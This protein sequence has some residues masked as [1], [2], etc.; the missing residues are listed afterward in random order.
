MQRIFIMVFG[1]FVALLFAACNANSDAVHVVETQNISL[2][3]TI[4]SYGNMGATVTAQATTMAEELSAA[5]ITLTAVNAQVK[6]LTNKMNAGVSQPVVV[7]SDSLGTGQLDSTPGANNTPDAVTQKDP[8]S[9]F[10]FATVV[11]AKSKDTD[12]CATSTSS[13]FN[14]TDPSIWVV[15][16]VRNYKRGTVFTAKWA[17]D[18]F[19]R[20]DSWTVSSDGAQICVHFYIQPKTLA[21]QPGNYTVTMSSGTVT[22]PPVQFTIQVQTP[23]TGA[24]TPSQAPS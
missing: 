6:D 22:A 5:R 12:G 20:E 7:Q 1:I 16:D 23:Q 13:T 24:P 2:Q 15:A 14:A 10:A 17:G 18:S 11:T 3:A 21:L 8:N 4:A 9:G 19:S